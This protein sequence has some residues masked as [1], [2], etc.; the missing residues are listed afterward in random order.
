M[1]GTEGLLEAT[2]WKPVG[3]PLKT[4]LR[5]ASVSSMNIQ[6]EAW[7]GHRAAAVYNHGHNF[8]TA[9][10]IFPRIAEFFVH[11]TAH[12]VSAAVWLLLLL[13][14]LFPGTFFLHRGIMRTGGDGWPRASYCIGVLWLIELAKWKMK[15]QQG[16]AVQQ[17][18]SVCSR[19]RNGDEHT[20]SPFWLLRDLAL[21][22]LPER[23]QPSNGSLNWH[24][25]LHWCTV[26]GMSWK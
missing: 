15:C 8:F 25:G 26:R 7:R 2:R 6:I 21:G 5:G 24:A 9:V 3:I 14:C 18:V 1:L 11:C 22:S 4:A 19:E 13:L 17:A 10:Q 16:R 20:W 23:L 12:I